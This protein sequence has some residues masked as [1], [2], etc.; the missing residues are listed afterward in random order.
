[1]SYTLADFLTTI[2]FMTRIGTIVE[3]AGKVRHTDIAATGVYPGRIGTIIDRIC[4]ID[5]SN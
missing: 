4:C 2:T 3:V 5:Q 1:M